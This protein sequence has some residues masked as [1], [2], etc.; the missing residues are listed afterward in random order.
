[1]LFGPA[2]ILIP[3]R[4]DRI[5]LPWHGGMQLPAS[6]RI[7]I[8]NLVGTSCSQAVSRQPCSEA[9][10]SALQ[11]LP[12]AIVEGSARGQRVVR[13]FGAPANPWWLVPCAARRR[14]WFRVAGIGLGS[15]NDTQF[16]NFNCRSIAWKRG[17][18]R[19]GSRSGSV[20]RSSRPG[21]RSRNAVSSDSRALGRLPHCA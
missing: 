11:R 19:R 6:I 21:S 14:A 2:E 3:I 10:F 8:L 12:Q 5:G 16:G 7:Y 17:S 18:S 20:F 9:A 15:V 1:M 13:R 4:S